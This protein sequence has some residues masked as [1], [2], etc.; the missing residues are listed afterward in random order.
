MLGYLSSISKDSL[1]DPSRDVLG[2]KAKRTG[3][4][5]NPFQRLHLSL[6]VGLVGIASNRDDN[7]QNRGAIKKIERFYSAEKGGVVDTGGGP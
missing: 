3:H 1:S 2:G 7:G 6:V 4:Q 5:D